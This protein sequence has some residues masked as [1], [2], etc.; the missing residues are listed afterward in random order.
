MNPKVAVVVL[1]Y[2]TQALLEKYL[3]DILASDYD[4]MDVWVVDNA[5]KD[6]SVSFL[7]SQFQEQVHIL[8]SEENRGYAG[9]YNWAL[10]QIDAEYYVLINSDVRVSK[11]WLYP[12]VSLA[13][14]N[15]K[16]GAIQPKILDDKK[17]QF[18]TSCFL[19]WQL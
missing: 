1:N 17:T 5:S 9:G 15:S 13:K 16:I 6:D 8:V 7:K 3:G 10:S 19:L 18:R 12:L 4:N 14:K 2:N 11:N